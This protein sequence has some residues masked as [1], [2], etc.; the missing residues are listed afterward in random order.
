MQK[1]KS[2][3]TYICTSDAKRLFV[4][5]KNLVDELIG[6]IGFTQMTLLHLLKR[7]PT[8]A[9]IKIADAV[10]VTIME[11]GMT[12]SAIAA[13][14]TFLGAPESLQG[15]VAAGLLGVGSRFAGTSGDCAALLEEIVDAPPA[16]RPAVADSIAQRFK[17]SRT[18]VPG[19]G[20]PVHNPIDP[21]TVKLIK[22]AR[23]QGVKGD[24]IAA[25]DLLSAAV[26]KSTGRNLTVN[27]SAGIGCVLAEIGLPPTIM[28][29]MSLIARCAGLVGHLLEEMEIPTGNFVWH[30]VEEAIP[31]AGSAKVEKAAS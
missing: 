18:P 25:L 19:F 5:D 9:E 23:E 26:N 21:R 12:P 2:P 7:M 31:Y 17:A 11:H 4:R 14:Q 15:A 10:L 1:N 30:L 24:Y 8:P 13:R 27:A 16:E 29:G 3:V 22:I 28:R 20:H 6:E